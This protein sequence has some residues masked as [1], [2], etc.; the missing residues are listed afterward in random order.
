MSYACPTFCKRASFLTQFSYS[1][2][3][4]SALGLHPL[5]DIYSQPVTTL[6][7]TVNMVTIK[8]ARLKLAAKNLL[9][10]R[11]RDL[12]GEKEVSAY[13]EG[14]RFSVALAYGS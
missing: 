4:A 2:C 3:P 11:I 1:R 6:D 9:N 14:R 8:G 7:A 12:Q 5:P 10:P 13:R